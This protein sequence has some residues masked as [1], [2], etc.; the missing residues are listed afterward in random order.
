MTASR[1]RFRPLSG[2]AEGVFWF[3][4]PNRSDP[5]QDGPSF[6]SLAKTVPP[7]VNAGAVESGVKVTLIGDVDCEIAGNVRA[8]NG[9][10]EFTPRLAPGAAFTFSAPLFADVHVALRNIFALRPAPI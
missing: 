9:S 2:K 4:R 7:F 5:E 3:G 8:F 10:K 6:R 1:A